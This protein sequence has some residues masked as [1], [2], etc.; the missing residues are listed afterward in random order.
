MEKEEGVWK[1]TVCVIISCFVLF[2][3]K[4]SGSSFLKEILSWAW[5]VE[6][7]N[8]VATARREPVWSE[9][10]WDQKRQ[11]ETSPAAG[12]TARNSKERSKSA[13]TCR[14]KSCRMMSSKLGRS[15]GFL[16]SMLAI[17]CL[18]GASNEDGIVYLASLMHLYVSF[19]FVVSN[20]GLP[21][22]I[23][24]LDTQKQAFRNGRQGTLWAIT[25]ESDLLFSF[26]H[27]GALT[28]ITQPK[29]QMSDSQPCPCL[30][31]TSGER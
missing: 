3:T 12:A 7:W 23:V 20:G 8:C 29:A 30:L 17:K 31:R 16:D 5:Q 1:L 11:S 10:L 19:R 24:Y 21:S 15:S 25:T 6:V 9:A 26:R 18:A 13:L 4:K 14:K 22:S 28:Y 2:A 27:S